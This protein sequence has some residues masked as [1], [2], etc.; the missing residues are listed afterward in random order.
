MCNVWLKIANYILR[1]SNVKNPSFDSALD[2][3][4]STFDGRTSNVENP[5]S[6]EGRFGCQIFDGGQYRIKNRIESFCRP[7]NQSLSQECAVNEPLIRLKR[8]LSSFCFFPRNFFGSSRI[9]QKSNRC[10]MCMIVIF[11]HFTYTTVGNCAHG[12]C[13]RY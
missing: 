7:L 4:Y 1:R 5:T 11:T 9:I 3:D 13:D 12:A 6:K 10:A 8:L 2:V